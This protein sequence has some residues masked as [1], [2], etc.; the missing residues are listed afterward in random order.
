MP[1]NNEAPMSN[2][3][4]PVSTT[5]DRRLASLT[6]AMGV[7]IADSLADPSV[8]DLL[9]N[10]DGNLWCVAHGRPRRILGQIPPARSESV[11]RLVASHTGAEI[12]RERPIVSGVLPGT[13][14]RFH[15]VLPPVAQRPVFAIRK[16]SEIIFTL[17]DFV[18]DGILWT[19]GAECLREA[20]HRRKNLLIVG[21]AGSGKTTLA[22]AILAERDFCDGRVVII[23]DT[24]ELQCSAPDRV[25]LVASPLSGGVTMDDLVRTTLRLFPDRIVVGEVRAGAETLSMLKAWATGHS[26][27]LCTLH[28]NGPH[29]A[30]Y[31]L[32]DLI[33]EVSA[34]IPRRTIA[35]AV[36]L[37]VCIE[38][39]DFKP[40][41][42]R[43]TAISRPRL[44]ESGEYAIEDVAI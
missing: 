2:D 7:A 9:A 26:G 31:R 1:Q 18:R 33:G 21:S 5:A 44:T 8:T 14:A 38:R 42:R 43:V 12:T 13:I 40:A 4:K 3:S 6:H 41:G 16:H 37:L 30:L 24:R 25:E 28:A 35:R 11:V 39:G 10:A 22:N 17:D 27:G 15:G 36:G 20:I 34:T 19:A 29:D 23:E 32:E